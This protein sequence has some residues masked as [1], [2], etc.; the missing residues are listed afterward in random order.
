HL[1]RVQQHQTVVHGHVM[2][3][4]M[5]AVPTVIHRV[6][7]VAV[8]IIVLAERIVLRVL[9]PLKPVHQLRVL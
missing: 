5:A 8:V 6:L 7:R 1:I 2:R 9:Q 4:I 3:D